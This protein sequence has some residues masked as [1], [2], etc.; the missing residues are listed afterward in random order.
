[1]CGRFGFFELRYFL[2]RL[3]QLELPFEEN[4][5]YG[6][7]PGYNI[8]PESTITVLLGNE[9]SN[10]L[11]NAHWGLIPHWAKAL[12]K[13]RPINARAESLGVK[14]YFRHMLNHRHCLIPA[15]GFYEWSAVRDASDASDASPKSSDMRDASEKQ[16]SDT[17]NASVKKQPWYIHR[18]DG[19]PMAFAG[20][21][22]TWEPTGREKPAVTSC[23]II[24][25]AANREMRPIHERMPV[26]LEPE[27]WRLWLEPE[28]GFAEKL[29]KPAAEGILELYPVSTRMNNPQ[30][31]RKDCI[32]K[33][34]ASVQGK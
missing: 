27:T 11:S 6:F 3:R 5:H 14:P 23:T 34:D 12:P 4:E 28:T 19:L 24:T 33:L 15:S 13:V 21:W 2:D 29:L 20:L 18:A 16:S 17:R 25:T 22:D 9:G 1:M 26:I 10:V 30:Y 8:A 32:E 7:M 31:I